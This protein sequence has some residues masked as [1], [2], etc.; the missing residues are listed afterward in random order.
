MRGRADRGDDRGAA[1]SGLV[2]MVSLAVIVLLFVAVLPIAAQTQRSDIAES[3][4]DAAAL[5]AAERIRE[6]ALERVTTLPA[7]GGL[8]AAMPANA[9]VTAAATYASRNS[10]DLVG[11]AYSVDWGRGTV[12]VEVLMRDSR[13][14]AP[15]RVRRAATAELGV[16]LSRC[17]IRTSRYMLPV[18]T[19]S[20]T[21]T[22]T[23]SPG[24]TPTPTPSPT[25]PPPPVW[26]SEH[27]FACSTTGGTDYVSPTF[28]RLADAREAGRVWLEDRLRVRLVR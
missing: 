18:P 25:P 12:D 7:G 1:V 11:P 3:A 22:P 27:R 16:A 2:M 19:P 4:A 15:A 5:A 10:S 24:A 9:G 13:A 23:P 14:D 28:A 20:P 21:P 26:V 6:L 17:E 8:V